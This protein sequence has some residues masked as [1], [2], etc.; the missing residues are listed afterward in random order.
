MEKS[1]RVMDGA[2]GGRKSRMLRAVLIFS[3]IAR[4]R[5]T[6]FVSRMPRV[7]CAEYLLVTGEPDVRSDRFFYRPNSRMLRMS[8]KQRNTDCLL[9]IQIGIPFT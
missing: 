6:V 3:A 9:L 2:K 7:L 5:N 4:K 8:V 1:G